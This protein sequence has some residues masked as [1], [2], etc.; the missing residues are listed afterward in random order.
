MSLLAKALAFEAIE[1]RNQV[2]SRSEA[3][4][5]AGELL[6][7]SGRTSSEYTNSMLQAIEEFGPYIVIAPGIALAHA[8]P[9]EHVIETG[10]SL[11]VLNEPIEFKHSQNDPVRLVFGLCALDHSSHIDLMAELAELL[12]DKAKV[13]LLLSSSDVNE[14]RTVIS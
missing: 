7:R 10:L 8:K 3:V 13:N 1:V 14:V 5:I 2:Q 4:S 6:V 11:L 12:S 9:A